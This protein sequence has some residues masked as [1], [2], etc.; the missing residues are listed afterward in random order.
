MSSAGKYRYARGL[1]R[2]AR[3]ATAMKANCRSG[4]EQPMRGDKVALKLRDPCR[5]QHD[6]RYDL[7]GLVRL[8]RLDLRHLY[9]NPTLSFHRVIGIL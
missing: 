2:A 9:C 8:V 4:W 6:L 5:S 3:R 1:T 7:R